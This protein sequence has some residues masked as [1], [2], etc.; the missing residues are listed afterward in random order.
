MLCFRI[1][2]TSGQNI[3]DMQ[4]YGRGMSDIEM[5][6]LTLKCR[7]IAP[8][9]PDTLGCFPFRKKDPF[10]LHETPHVYFMGNAKKYQTKCLQGTINQNFC[11]FWVFF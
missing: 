6:E 4:V 8:T 5:M 7:N 3:H 10:L 9:A 1:L 11:F 2:G